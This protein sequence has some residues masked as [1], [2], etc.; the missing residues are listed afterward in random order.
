[1]TSNS[2]EKH[3]I[4][5]NV[6]ETMFIKKNIFSHLDVKEINKIKKNL[7]LINPKKMFDANS[8]ENAYIENKKFDTDIKLNIKNFKVSSL[9]NKNIIEINYLQ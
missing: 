4:L 5:K 8:N 6:N 2:Y 1:M 7:S 3:K 9:N